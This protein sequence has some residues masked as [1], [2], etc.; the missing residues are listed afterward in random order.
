MAKKIV[1]PKEVVPV[2]HPVPAN[3][4]A[5]EGPNAL[6]ILN[7][8]Q[9][10]PIAFENIFQELVRINSRLASLEALVKYTALEKK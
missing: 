2:E 10:L 9:K 5:P 1:K 7:Q 4:P 6:S 3:A 8:L